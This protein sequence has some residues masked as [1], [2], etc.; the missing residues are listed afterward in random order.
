MSFNSDIANSS[1]EKISLV[2]VAPRIRLTGW[3][4]VS[5]T[6]YSQISANGRPKRMWAYASVGGPYLDPPELEIYPAPD[7][8]SI[9]SYGYFYDESINTLY[10]NWLRGGTP[11]A[12]PG[13]PQ[14]GVTASFEIFISSSNQYGLSDPFDPASDVVEWEGKLLEAPF[15][16][17]G[18]RD[19]LFGFLPI[20]NSTI[21]VVNDG[22]ISPPLDRVWYNCDVSVYILTGR[23]MQEAIDSGGI[24]QVFIGFVS[25]ISQEGGILSINCADYLSKL[26]N[27]V[28]QPQATYN[29]ADF[30]SGEQGIFNTLPVREIYGM[31]DSFR[32]VNLAVDGPSTVTNRHWGVS[33][34]G[35]YFV[36][37]TVDH[38]QANTATETYTIERPQYN[39][40]D[41]IAFLD[42]PDAFALVTAVNHAAKRIFHSPVTR[43][44][45]PGDR[46]TRAHI[47]NVSIVDRAGVQFFLKFGES[48]DLFNSF[49]TN[50]FR[51]KDDFEAI[52]GLA[53]SPFD[54]TQD[55]IVCRVYGS[56]APEF[57]SDS[58]EV[59]STSDKGGVWS[60]SAIL[61]YRLLRE[62]GIPTD[63]IDKDSWELAGADSSAMGFVVPE[64]Y[65]TDTE[66]RTYIDIIADILA[67]SLLNVNLIN[68]AD[69]SV[70]I[71]LS[72]IQPIAGPSD[73]VVSN[74]D[75]SQFSFEE[76][77]GDVYSDVRVDFHKP[78]FD[79]NPGNYNI[80][81]HLQADFATN[82]VES[83]ENM[84][85]KTKQYRLNTLHTDQSEGIIFARRISYI[86]SQRRRLI[87]LVLPQKFVGES[88][89]GKTFTIQRDLLPGFPYVY[90]SLNEIKAVVVEVEKTIETV[91]LTLD[92]QKGVQDN[93]GS[94]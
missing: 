47:A 46:I 14:P 26:N 82:H 58:S 87:S 32:P 74:E 28:V 21:R 85:Q 67:G 11:D 22:W 23:T 83:T 42:N 89:L 9:A 56:G 6:V 94:W 35:P 24:R 37:Y 15:P 93:S 10:I 17:S 78:D 4:L 41:T 16:T 43:T 73:F 69:G 38:T 90:G 19:S 76:D 53:V 86:L 3:T 70:K 51:L 29:S 52:A 2:K 33:A 31:V 84:Y 75:F 61:V 13:G 40:G 64:S 30:P 60:R 48:Y 49:G 72:K 25:S 55:R 71:G 8:A 5:G 12:P 68:A 34:S 81:A 66:T 36:E 92:D 88:L 62:A 18:S 63:L 27:T 65:T 50:G 91:T 20:S 1:V 57:Y 44:V 80:D 77:N 7:L 39:P 79:T 59:L 45:A 54:P